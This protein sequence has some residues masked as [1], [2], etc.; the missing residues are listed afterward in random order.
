M[1]DDFVKVIAIPS[2]FLV[3][4]ALPHTCTVSP[5]SSSVMSAQYCNDE[6]SLT[7]LQELRVSVRS[8]IHLPRLPRDA[9]TLVV[10][11]YK[12]KLRC[13]KCLTW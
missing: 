11:N 6:M 3:P 10:G 4:Q 9:D 2:I 12:L 1:N 7:R 13:K 5:L 8:L